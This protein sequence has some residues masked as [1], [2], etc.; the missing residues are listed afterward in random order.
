MNEYTFFKLLRAQWSIKNDIKT[1]LFYIIMGFVA[2][3]MA[4]VLTTAPVVVCAIMT[5]VFALYLIVIYQAIKLILMTIFC[6]FVTR[7]AKRNNLKAK[8]IYDEA[9]TW[10]Q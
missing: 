7:Y 2:F 10:R 8:E 4:L 5:L 3:L 6:W 9:L 1:T